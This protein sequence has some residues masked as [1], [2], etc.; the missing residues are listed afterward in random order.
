M[1][2]K[3][4]TITSLFVMF[5]SS[6]SGYARVKWNEYHEEIIYFNYEGQNIVL[7]DMPSLPLELSNQIDVRNALSYSTMPAS[8][9][10]ILDSLLR[11]HLEIHPL[12]PFIGDNFPNK[13]IYNFHTKSNHGDS[14]RPVF[15][16]LE[17]RLNI[18]VGVD[19]YLVYTSG[20]DFN[21]RLFLLNVVDNCLRSIILVSIDNSHE[22]SAALTAEFIDGRIELF[23]NGYFSMCNRERYVSSQRSHLKTFSLN[24]RGLL[25]EVYSSGLFFFWPNTSKEYVT[26]L[27]SDTLVFENYVKDNI[28]LSSLPECPASNESTIDIK[29]VTST[30]LSS[31]TPEESAT[32]GPALCKDNWTG[33]DF[34]WLNQVHCNDEVTSYLVLTVG[35]GLYNGSRIFMVNVRDKRVMSVAHVSSIDFYNPFRPTPYCHSFLNEG[36]ITIHNDYGESALSPMTVDCFRYEVVQRDLTV[37]DSIEFCD[38]DEKDDVLHNFNLYESR[39]PQSSKYMLILDKDGYLTRK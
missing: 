27:Q 7:K 38:V 4:I 29:Q 26:N 39:M 35:A 9:S 30:P 37:L 2:N 14:R 34:Y 11:D 31:F 1:L 32:I 17:T 3:M 5:I 13:S 10:A 36:I 21:S 22:K 33:N 25:S 16:L 15:N 20:F 28:I 24:E 6:V 18:C 12:K 19:S 23:E 8:S